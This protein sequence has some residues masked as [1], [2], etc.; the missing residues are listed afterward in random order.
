MGGLSPRAS[1]WAYKTDCIQSCN[2]EILQW[3]RHQ[4]W[5]PDSRTK[6]RTALKPCSWG[7]ACK[8]RK[9]WINNV[10]SLANVDSGCVN[11]CFNDILLVLRTKKCTHAAWWNSGS[12]VNTWFKNLFGFTKTV[13]EYPSSLQLHK[14]IYENH[15]CGLRCIFLF[16]ALN[17]ITQW[18]SYC[19]PFILL[20][21]LHEYSF[22]C[23]LQGTKCWSRYERKNWVKPNNLKVFSRY[24]EPSCC[25]F[26]CTFLSSWF[27]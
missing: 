12:T 2:I 9:S 15:T 1:S 25:D 4:S 16:S 3:R 17:I 11:E 5:I 20:Q 23:Q 26:K 8:C 18:T 19:L 6:Q 10:G 21:N 14:L 27:H 13:F 7:A 22:K 24:F